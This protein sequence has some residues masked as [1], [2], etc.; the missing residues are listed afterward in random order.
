MKADREIDITA[1][2]CPMTFVRTKLALEKMKPGEILTVILRGEE[3]L[4][5]VPRAVQDHGHIVRSQSELEE[6]L[7]KLVIEVR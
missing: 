3:P 6:G 2:T 5:N 7:H 1:D 4:Q